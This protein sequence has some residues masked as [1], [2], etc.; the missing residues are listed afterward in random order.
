MVL[1][2]LIRNEPFQE[3]DPRGESCGCGTPLHGTSQILGPK[4]LA[5]IHYVKK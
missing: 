3:T 4:S 2:E 1:N 5:R